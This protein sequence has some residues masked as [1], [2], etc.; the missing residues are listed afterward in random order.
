MRLTLRCWPATLSRLFSKESHFRSSRLK[1]SRKNKVDSSRLTSAPEVVGI[2]WRRLDIEPGFS[3]AWAMLHRC[4]LTHCIRRLRLRLP[5]LLAAATGAAAL[6]GDG[7][8]PLEFDD[9]LRAQRLSEPQVSPDGQWIAYVVTRADK[10]EN[11]TDSD[12]WL[13]PMAGG[14]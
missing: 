14:E 4:Y 13:A 7:R 1:F 10:A 9:L 8:R 2:H 11:R 12:V 3:P 6:A 5:C